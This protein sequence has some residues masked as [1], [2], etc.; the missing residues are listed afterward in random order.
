MRQDSAVRVELENGSSWGIGSFPPFPVQLSYRWVTDEGHYVAGPEALRTP[1]RPTLHPHEKASYAMT[2]AAPDEPGHYRLRV[3]LVQELVRWFDG[4]P[5]P[6]SAERDSCCR[7]VRRRLEYRLMLLV[8]LGIRDARK[9]RTARRIIPE[10]PLSPWRPADVVAVA[11]DLGIATLLDAPLPIALIVGQRL[12]EAK[13]RRRRG[14]RAQAFHRKRLSAIASERRFYFY[15]HLRVVA[16]CRELSFERRLVEPDDNRA[17]D[18]PRR[19]GHPAGIR[20]CAP[21]VPSAGGGAPR[22]R[23]RS[24]GRHHEPG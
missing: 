19:V 9:Q 22:L 24:G 5:S 21:R 20:S 3:T 18:G 7:L 6:V 4:L 17:R 13:C 10:P 16:C 11:D 8:T 1:L 12:F 23:R 2:I 14:G 15:P